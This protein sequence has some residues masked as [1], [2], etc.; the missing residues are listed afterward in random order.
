MR[1]S[2]RNVFLLSIF[3]IFA[4]I[5]GFWD[6]IRN[7]LMKSL[8]IKRFLMK[9]LMED[10]IRLFCRP[11]SYKS[12]CIPRNGMYILQPRSKY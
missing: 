4:K 9:S 12:P 10:E 8:M 2:G 3:W 6:F 1:Y 11:K 7:L 5:L